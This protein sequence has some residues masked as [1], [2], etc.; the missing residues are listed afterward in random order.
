[1]SGAGRPPVVLCKTAR[2]QAHQSRR[3]RI[4][5]ASAKARC[6]RRAGLSQT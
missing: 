3:L 5:R 1:V 4:S 6:S 2:P